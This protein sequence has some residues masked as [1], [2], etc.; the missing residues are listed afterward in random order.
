[1]KLR[2][3]LL[4]WIA[5][6]LSLLAFQLRAQE[7]EDILDTSNWRPIVVN[8]PEF[9]RVQGKRQAGIDFFGALPYA[10]PP[11]G[12]LRFAPPEPPT[13]WHPA[14]L[15]ST[16]FGPD[17]WQ[18][19]DPLLNP[20]ADMEHMSEDCLHLNVFSPAGQASR[21]T[22]M[23]VLV[24]LHGGAFQQGGARRPEYDG[25][26][27]A[28]RGAIVVTLNYRLGALVCIASFCLVKLL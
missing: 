10:A 3:G 9:G 4:I 15:D 28:E 25:R 26:R 8:L 5:W 21:N 7:S 6:I 19:V 1:M 2:G 20:G 27:L 23:P 22:L 24:W 18:L 17:C 13:P 16:S 11:V 14:K 12:N